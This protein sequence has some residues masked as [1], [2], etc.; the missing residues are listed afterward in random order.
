MRKIITK[1]YLAII[2]KESLRKASLKTR[3]CH[4]DSKPDLL[5]FI[6]VLAIS[7]EPLMMNGESENRQYQI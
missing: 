7:Q 6:C 2:V 1:Y 3:G 4:N 5:I